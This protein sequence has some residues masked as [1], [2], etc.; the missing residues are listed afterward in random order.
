MGATSLL[1]LRP[2]ISLK[3]RLQQFATPASHAASAWCFPVA[4]APSISCGGRTD[5]PSIPN[6]P[7][8]PVSV[9]QHSAADLSECHAHQY[10]ISKHISVRPSLQVLQDETEMLADQPDGLI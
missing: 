1:W 7:P 6:S 8:L 10:F 5:R 4:S 9:R 2:S 3:R